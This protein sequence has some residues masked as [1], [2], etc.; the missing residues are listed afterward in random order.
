MSRSQFVLLLVVCLSA[1]ASPSRTIAATPTIQSVTISIPSEWT[2]AIM[3]TGGTTDSIIVKFTDTGGTLNIEPQTQAFEITG[4]QYTDSKISFKVKHQNEMSFSG[5]VDGSQIIGQVEQNGQTHSFALLPLSS[6]ANNSLNDFPGTYQFQ[7]GEALL[8]NLAPEYSSSGLYFFGQGLMVTHFGTGAIRALYPIAN[9]TFLV[10][11]ARAIGYP[12]KEQITFQ[13][14]S[15]GNVLGPTWQTRNP[16][17][18]ELSD[19]ELA[20]RLALQSEIVHFTIADGTN[21]TGLLTLPA[22]SGP[23]PAI[24]SLHG[25]EPGTKDNFGSQQ[26]S[27]FMASHGIAI[28][29]YDKRGAGESE[30][31]YVE[32]ASERNLNLTAQDAIAGV[33][34]LKTRPEIKADQIGLTGFS[35]AGWVIPLAASQSEDIAYFIILSGPVTSVGHEDLY[36]AYTNDGESSVQYSMEV[37]T[38]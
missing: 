16:D 25:S 26:M 5:N 4:I 22:T 10:G 24:M 11:S 27:A 23:Y 15:N 12:F 38:K 17:T 20:H 31:S 33:E 8:I 30:G 37:I 35:Q 9:D 28:L 36:S 14:D 32:A 1:C 6:N 13:R 34:Y 18:G 19:P 29:T 7:S 21:L 3:Y 2:G